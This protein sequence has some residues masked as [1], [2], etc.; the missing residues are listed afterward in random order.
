MPTPTEPMR[1]A[2]QA[3]WDA[4]EKKLARHEFYRAMGISNRGKYLVGNRM[5]ERRWIA[6]TDN[7]HAN[8]ITIT[9]AGMKALGVAN[10]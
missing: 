4:P 2:L 6:Q 8:D 3:L 10:V 1:R 7:W 5:L 9:F